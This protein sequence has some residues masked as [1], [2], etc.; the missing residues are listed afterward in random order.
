MS[1]RIANEMIFLAPRSHETAYD[2]LQ[3]TI[4]NG[5]PY[6][7]V[8]AF[9]D[10]NGQK[11]LSGYSK[12][13]AWGNVASKKGSWDLMKPGDLILFYAH[14]EFVFAGRCLYKQ[15]SEDLSDALWPRSPRNG[16][17][18]WSCVFFVHD[19][20]PISIP[21]AIINEIGSYKLLALQG[22]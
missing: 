20:R 16:N 2:N 13:Y 22:F 17:K 11:V 15:L 8:A 4:E 19:I 7:K 3:S 14:K 1:S 9:L 21:L 5:I 12:V 6:S 10:E 18:P